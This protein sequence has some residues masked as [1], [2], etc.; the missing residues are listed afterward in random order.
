[1]AC[2]CLFGKTA[3]SSGLSFV[4]ICGLARRWNIVVAR[5]VATRNLFTPFVGLSILEQLTGSIL[6]SL[7]K[8]LSFLLQ[9]TR[10]LLGNR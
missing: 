3:A 6:A 5:V 10:C 8:E 4:R 2:S 1:M 9:S 7:Y